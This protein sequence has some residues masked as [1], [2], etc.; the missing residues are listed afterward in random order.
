M[1]EATKSRRINNRLEKISGQAW[2]VFANDAVVAIYDN[3]SKACEVASRLMMVRNNDCVTWG[4]LN[5]K[6]WQAA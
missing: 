4:P 1:N 3:G 5:M 2:A 6:K